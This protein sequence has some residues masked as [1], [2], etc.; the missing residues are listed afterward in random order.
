MAKS[1]RRFQPRIGFDRRSDRHQFERTYP[2]SSVQ[3]SLG[4]SFMS[5]DAVSAITSREPSLRAAMQ[6][7]TLHESQDLNTILAQDSDQ[8][9]RLGFAV[10]FDASVRD[11]ST[12]NSFLVEILL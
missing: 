2:Q 3:N 7:P 12:F 8:L 9:K 11:G 6:T 4:K 1:G 10:P 5:I